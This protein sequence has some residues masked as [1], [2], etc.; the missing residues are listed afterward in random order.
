M[1]R[2]IQILFSLEDKSDFYE[3][4][5]KSFYHFVLL[6]SVNFEN[7]YKKRGKI[8]SLLLKNIAENIAE[9]EIY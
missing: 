5:A 4:L 1:D 8:Y 3:E 7:A 9:K 2:I 6:C